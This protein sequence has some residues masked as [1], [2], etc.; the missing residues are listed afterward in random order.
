MFLRTLSAIAMTIALASPGAIGA[1]GPDWSACL[2][3][4]EF[5][6]S[7]GEPLPVTLAELC[8]ASGE[9]SWLETVPLGA[10]LSLLSYWDLR[11]LLADLNRPV[12]SGGLDFAALAALSTQ[13]SAVP[14][15]GP[16]RIERVLTWLDNW[17][18]SNLAQRFKKAFKRWGDLDVPD[19]VGV[20]LLRVSVVLV[21][22]LALYVIASEL[23]PSRVRWPRWSRPVRAPVASGAVEAPLAPAW[24]AIEAA[25]VEARPALL[26]RLLIS[27]FTSRGWLP[28]NRSLTN[29]ECA[30]VVRTNAAQVGADFEAVVS[31]LDPVL[32]G[33]KTLT[34]SEYATLMARGARLVEA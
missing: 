5:R 30:K 26:L 22:V 16:N 25:P 24:A 9:S 10:E 34:A 19:W 17:I 27:I 2:R 4:L 15:P 28:A 7:S 3:A 6:Y 21:L 14:E 11:A 31:V 29:R 8:S 18:G 1:D 20:T 32:Y 12:R 13:T 23:R 33:R